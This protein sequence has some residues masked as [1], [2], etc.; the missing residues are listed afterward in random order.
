MNVYD[1]ELRVFGKDIRNR[2]PVG[3]EAEDQHD[4][5]AVALDAGPPAEHLGVDGDPIESLVSV[6]DVDGPTS[7]PADQP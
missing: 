5:D 1:V 6:H 2:H 3:E 7:G 4:R